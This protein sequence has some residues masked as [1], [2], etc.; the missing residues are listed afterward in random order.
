[1]DIEKNYNY[2]DNNRG[3]FTSFILTSMVIL[4]NINQYNPTKL[5]SYI[6]ERSKNS[7]G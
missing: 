3:L 6:L 5:C 7:C 2:N 1:M 4:R